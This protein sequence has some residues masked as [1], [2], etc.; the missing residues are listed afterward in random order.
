VFILDWFDMRPLINFGIHELEEQFDAKKH[1]L[2]FLNTLLSELK[3]RKT[4]RAIDLRNRTVQALEVLPKS[5]PPVRPKSQEHDEIECPLPEDDAPQSVKL[6]KAVK[7]LSDEPEQTSV[8]QRV[9]LPRA[10]TDLSGMAEPERVMLAWTALEVLSPQSFLKPE[11]LAGGER[12]RITRLDAAVP[13]ENGGEKSRPNYRLYYQI[14]LGTIQMEPAITQLLTVY[15]DKRHERP[16]K[17]GESI[18]AAIVVDREGRR[19]DSDAVAL[20]SFAWGVPVA[21]KGILKHWEIGLP[22]NVRCL[23]N[24]I[25]GSGIKTMKA[26]CVH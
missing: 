26:T 17:N 22:Q 2:A 3:N 20:S 24:S 19:P 25:N 10:E 11:D 5:A 14:V 15:T 13:W 7:G 8:P 21:L 23:K 1:D 18:L 4:K 9:V 6:P 16:S 12:N